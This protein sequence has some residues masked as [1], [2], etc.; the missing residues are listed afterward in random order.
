MLHRLFRFLALQIRLFRSMSGFLFRISQDKQSIEAHHSKTY[1]QRFILSFWFTLTLVLQTFHY[2]LTE[3]KI[4]IQV[5]ATAGLY[6]NS[7]LWEFLLLKNFQNKSFQMAELINQMLKFE[8][9]L[10]R[11]STNYSYA[12]L[13]YIDV[14]AFVINSNVTYLCIYL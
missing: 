10:D 4:S 6:T 9:R 14:H 7:F 3:Q 13:L 5:L 1:R 12:L 8:T 11:K 2:I